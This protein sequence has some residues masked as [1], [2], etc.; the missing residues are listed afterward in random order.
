M[1]GLIYL[2]LFTSGMGHKLN[3]IN[4]YHDKCHI[5]IYF[6]LEVVIQKQLVTSRLFQSHLETL[7]SSQTKDNLSVDGC[8]TYS[9]DTISFRSVDSF[10]RTDSFFPIC[11][12]SWY[13]KLKCNFTRCSTFLIFTQVTNWSSNIPPRTRHSV[14]N[15]HFILE[16]SEFIILHH[17]LNTPP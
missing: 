6:T 5:I 15:Y 9:Q 14:W 8:Q 1:D 2:T 16:N 17:G 12:K 13:F 7:N 10:F 3:Y 11:S 4:I